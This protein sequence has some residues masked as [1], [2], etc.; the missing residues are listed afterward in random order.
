[1][2][3]GGVFRDM[4]AWTKAAG[5]PVA[6]LGVSIEQLSDPLR[7]EMRAFLDGCCFAWFRDR[8]SLEQLGGHPRAFV[9]PDFTWT[10]PLPVLAPPTSNGAAVCLRRHARLD[11]AAWQR[12]LADLGRPARPWPLYFE[13]GGD[14]DPLT[15]A[16]PG[17]AIGDEFSVRPLVDASAVVSMRYHGVIFGLQSGRPAVGVGSQPKLSRFMAEQGV[18]DWRLDESQIDA[19]PALLRSWDEQPDAVRTSVLELRHRQVE[20]A[21]TTAQGA[22]DRLLTAAEAA[23][24]SRSAWSRRVRALIDVVHLS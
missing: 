17:E 11:V 23:S 5:I 9:A 19:L 2:N 12:V 24:R 3:R 7:A 21:V 8:G 20:A 16:M 18:G 13:Q 15:Q 4:A 22:L 6:L 10:Y 14:T 1:M